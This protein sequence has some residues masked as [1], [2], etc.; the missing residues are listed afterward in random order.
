LK[1]IFANID[2]SDTTPEPSEIAHK[3]QH[4]ARLWE[5]LLQATG[6]KL[7]LTKCF[8][9]ILHWKFDNEGEPSPM[10][11]EE[12]EEKGVAITI[13]QDDGT[14]TTTIQ[15][16][17]CNKAHRTLGLYKTIT[18][19]QDE[20][21]KQTKEKSK[22]TTIAVG[23]AHLLKDHARIAW[24]AMYIPAVAYPFVATYMTE[25]D[26]VKVE[27]KALMTFLPREGYNWNTVRAVVY[28][29]DQNGGLE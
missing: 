2:E 15:H 5:R 27:N 22:K 21:L 4:D 23:A 20:Q 3:L 28:R 9:Y 29:P 10:T 13:Q 7:E 25:K 14:H 16:Y 26:L 18:G 8:Y 6:G 17:D 11:K 19:N 12:L 24:N 1:H